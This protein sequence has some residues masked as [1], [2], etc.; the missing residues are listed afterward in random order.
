MPITSLNLGTALILLI[1]L[2]CVWA[3]FLYLCVPYLLCCAAAQLQDASIAQV[4]FWHTCLFLHGIWMEHSCA[5]VIPDSFM[6]DT[7]CKSPEFE[8]VK[9]FW[10]PNL[11]AATYHPHTPQCF[12]HHCFA[13]TK[14]S[15]VTECHTPNYLI[16]CERQIRK[17]LPPGWPI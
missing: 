2:L 13:V 3:L 10:S 7:S 5:K 6:E 4:V 1:T 15:N 17:S 11:Y 14:A 9:L 12:E 8:K 16:T